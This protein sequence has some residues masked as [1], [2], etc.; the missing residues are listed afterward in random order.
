MNE[1]NENDE[2]RLQIK[3]VV[4]NLSKKIEHDNVKVLNLNTHFKE[5][6]EYSIT[7]TP[8]TIF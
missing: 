6:S 4:E 3:K 2:K 8:M 5:F 7:V 1:K